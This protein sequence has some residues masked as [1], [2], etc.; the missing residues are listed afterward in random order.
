MGNLEEQ[1]DGDEVVK[2]ENLRREAQKIQAHNHIFGPV[3]NGYPGEVCVVPTIAYQARRGRRWRENCAS[4]FRHMD[5]YQRYSQRILAR[6][7]PNTR[8]KNTV[9]YH[10][11]IMCQ[12]TPLYPNMDGPTPIPNRAP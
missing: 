8:F 6:K 10:L 11:Y 3:L 4:I 5:E 1:M 9:C 2:M 12:T 7:I